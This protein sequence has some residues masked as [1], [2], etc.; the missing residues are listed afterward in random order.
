MQLK[1]R[2]IKCILDFCCFFSRL[3]FLQRAF[4]T[5]H[6]LSEEST[7]SAGN[8]VHLKSAPLARGI[9]FCIHANCEHYRVVFIVWAIRLFMLAFSLYLVDVV[10]EK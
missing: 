10:F 9:Q 2:K 3:L 4:L 1:K 7:P 5:F 6:A 8:G